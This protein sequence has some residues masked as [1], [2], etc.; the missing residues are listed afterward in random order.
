MIHLGIGGSGNAMVKHRAP[1]ASRWSSKCF[2]AS[3]SRASS[4]QSPPPPGSTSP[5][6][7][8]KY[9]TPATS[10]T[11]FGLDCFCRRCSVPGRG[12]RP[13]RRSQCRKRK[14]PVPTVASEPT[15]SGCSET[16]RSR[17]L[18]DGPGALAPAVQEHR[19]SEWAQGRT[20]GELASNTHNHTNKELGA[21]PIVLSHFVAHCRTR[22]QARV[23]SGAVASARVHGQV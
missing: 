11:V 2:F 14:K 20:Q 4:P 1:C 7:D 21:F 13:R 5:N 6:S 3:L 16:A 12:L 19:E 15:H 9:G 17:P 8:I 10:Q 18:E 23:L 22:R